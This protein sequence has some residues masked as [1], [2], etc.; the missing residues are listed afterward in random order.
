MSV[1]SIDNAFLRVPVA[2]LSQDF[3]SMTM[4]RIAQA[5]IRADLELASGYQVCSLERPEPK[6]YAHEV[7]ALARQELERVTDSATRAGFPI[8]T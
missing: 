5:I 3:P 7:A 4:E 6:T 8:R 2:E 1:A